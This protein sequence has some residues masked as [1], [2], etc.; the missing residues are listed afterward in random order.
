MI[1]EMTIADRLQTLGILPREGNFLT[2]RV[3]RELISKVGFSA[4]ELTDFKIKQDGEF[5]TWDTS[6]N[7]TVE[8]DFLNAELDI[9]KSALIK[10]DKEEKLNNELFDIYEK[11]MMR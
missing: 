11:F 1:I 2:M 8:K 9:I 3:I 4:T 7:T 5:V 10:L 6:I